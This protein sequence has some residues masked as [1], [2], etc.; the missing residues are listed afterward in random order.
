MARAAAV[1]LRRMMRLDPRRPMSTGRTATI[2]LCEVTLI[3]P[4]LRCRTRWALVVGN[5]R[6]HGWTEWINLLSTRRVV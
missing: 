2:C 4:T 3:E 6:G 5:G 1:T